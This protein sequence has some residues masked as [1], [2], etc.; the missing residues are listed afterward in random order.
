M[1]PKLKN[2]ETS[3]SL[4]PLEQMI[5]RAQDMLLPVI[6]ET[7]KKVE[8][9]FAFANSM[10]SPRFTMQE[11]R[12]AILFA[13]QEEG[14]CRTLW[15]FCQ[16]LTASAR[17]IKHVDARTSLERRTGALLERKAGC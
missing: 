14:D 15:Q 9:Y 5:R 16:G 12:N 3:I 7:D 17:E 4:S 6:G 11:V 13:E 1:V 10:R 8:T 2:L